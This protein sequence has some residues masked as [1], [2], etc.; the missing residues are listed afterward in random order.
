[1]AGGFRFEERTVEP[2]LNTLEWNG[3]AVR[4]EPKVKQVLVCLADHRGELY[5]KSSLFE[6]SG[7]IPLLRTKCLRAVSPNCVRR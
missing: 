3:H 2:Q 1:M 4:L 7:Q 6:P 5:P